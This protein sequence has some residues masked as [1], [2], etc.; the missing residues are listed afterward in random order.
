[1]VFGYGVLWQRIS[2]G[3][4]GKPEGLFLVPNFILFFNFLLNIFFIYIS[5]V[6]PFLISLPKPPVPSPSHCSPTHLLMLPDPGIPLHRGIEPS[7][8]QGPS[9]P[10]MMNRAPFCYICGWS[11][12]SLH[13]YSLV[14]DLVPGS[15]GGTGWFLLLFL[16]WGC[17]PLQLLG[18]FL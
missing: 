16:L 13:V 18:S 3:S 1:L 2:S 7:Q 10:L 4:R 5:N 17:K 12:G 11:H 8:D 9:L 14:G 15:S 6:I